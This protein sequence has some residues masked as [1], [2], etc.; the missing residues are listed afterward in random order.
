LF[1]WPLTSLRD[2]LGPWMRLDFKQ[3]HFSYFISF[4]CFPI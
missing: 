1:S 2:D 4:I 3:L